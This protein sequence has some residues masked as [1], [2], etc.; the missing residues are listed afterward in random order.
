MSCIPPNSACFLFL[1]IAIVS[2]EA[3]P[4]PE[5]A[6]DMLPAAAPEDYYVRFMLAYGLSRFID[7]PAIQDHGSEFLIK[8]AVISWRLEVGYQFW[9]ELSLY[10]SF[11]SSASREGQLYRDGARI[12]ARASFGLYASGIGLAYYYKPFALQIAS[13]YRHILSASER[14]GPTL[15]TFSGAGYGINITKEW[16][17]K[18]KGSWGLSFLYQRDRLDGIAILSPSMEAAEDYDTQGEYSSYSLG[19]SLRWD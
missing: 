1:C 18:G 2:F 9:K 13:E 7:R 12:G 14:I 15:L 16:H 17:L 6:S 4:L 11:H 5:Q 19:L 3:Y 8:A 10:G